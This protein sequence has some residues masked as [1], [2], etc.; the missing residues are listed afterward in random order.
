MNPQR[1]DTSTGAWRL[2]TSHEDH[3]NNRV[4]QRIRE[5]QGCISGI[6]APS[7]DRVCLLIEFCYLLELH[8]QVVDLYARLDRN[9]V[10]PDWVR[11][12]DRIVR[13]SRMKL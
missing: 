7:V 5:I 6:I 8:Q 12:V 9:E 4:D 1:D 2:S 3:L 13:A 10:E 11:R